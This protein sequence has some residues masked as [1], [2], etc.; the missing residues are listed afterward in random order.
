MLER[1]LLGA[2]AASALATSDLERAAAA[3]ELARV[4]GDA[5]A[6]GLLAFE[7]EARLAE[8]KASPRHASVDLADLA[9][10]ARA[11]GHLPLARRVEALRGP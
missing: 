7:V 8:A 1:R 3:E 4:A 6:T 10:R 9:A 2:S 11:A 5:A